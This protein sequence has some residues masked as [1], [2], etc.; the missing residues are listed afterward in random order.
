MK[1]VIGTTCWVIVNSFKL[2]RFSGNK[3]E[4]NPTFNVCVFLKICLFNTTLFV[5]IF[6]GKSFIFDEVIGFPPKMYLNPMNI[7]DRSFLISSA[8]L[9]TEKTFCTKQ[10]IKHLANIYIE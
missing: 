7:S 5:V 4:I 10:K 2:L 3:F 6:R 8:I 9:N 1:M